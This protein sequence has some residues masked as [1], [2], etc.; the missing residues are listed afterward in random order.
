MR[1]CSTTAPEIHM[2]EITEDTPGLYTAVGGQPPLTLTL[3][4]PVRRPDVAV[5]VIEM[6]LRE[7]E[8][9]GD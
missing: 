7:S 8:S 1:S 5:P 6:F 3:T 4:L 9:A 2:R